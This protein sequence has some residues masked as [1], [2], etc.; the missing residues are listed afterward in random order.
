[1]DKTVKCEIPTFTAISPTTIRISGGTNSI[2]PHYYEKELVSLEISKDWVISKGQIVTV[3]KKNYKVNIIK[4]AYKRKVLYYDLKVAEKNKSAIFITP[5]LG[6]TRKLW[7]YDQLLVNTF[8]GTKGYVGN[9]IV[10]L[11]RQS[12][13][14]IFVKFIK[15]LQKFSNFKDITLYDDYIVVVFR[16]PKAHLDNYKKFKLGQY[17]QMSS[18][19]KLK[20]LSYHDMD[21]D[22]IIGQILFKTGD[23]KKKL[24]NRLGVILDKE[25]EL[26]SIPDLNKELLNINYYL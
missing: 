5:M 2:K 20:I 1:M 17:S 4:K 25:A 24:E 22:N 16:V 21:I 13:D 10:L 3:K 7:M 6:G 14:P 26:Y 11:Y 18:E 9:N 23:R 8:I 12:T 15:T 19:Y